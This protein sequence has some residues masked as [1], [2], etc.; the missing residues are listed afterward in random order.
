MSEVG[1]RIAS[2]AVEPQP[3]EKIFLGEDNIF[4][5]TVSGTSYSTT[6]RIMATSGVSS[7]A[8][9]G[10]VHFPVQIDKV[11]VGVTFLCTSFPLLRGC[12]ALS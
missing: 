6:D 3:E 4:Q 7:E 5:L 10:R 11:D 12:E 1:V 2:E 9:R 8:P